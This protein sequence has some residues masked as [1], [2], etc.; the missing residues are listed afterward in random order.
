MPLGQQVER[1]LS[2]ADVGLDAHDCDLKR[3][4]G[5]SGEREAHL[6]DEHAEGGLVEQRRRGGQVKLGAQRSKPRGRLS[7]GKDGD[8]EGRACVWVRN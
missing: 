7:R 5:G 1:G 8:R 6:R 3:R 4:G 2:D